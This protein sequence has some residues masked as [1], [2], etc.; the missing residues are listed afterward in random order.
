M[1]SIMNMLELVSVLGRGRGNGRVRATVSA[2]EHD[3]GS[4]PALGSYYIADID[5]IGGG[6]YSVQSGGFTG[7]SSS[8][9]HPSDDLQ[10]GTE[11]NSDHGVVD[12]SSSSLKY[13]AL[14]GASHADW[15]YSGGGASLQRVPSS[16]GHVSWVTTN[17]W[18]QDGNTC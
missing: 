18:V 15:T 13:Y 4:G 7:T 12:G 8:Q 1:G 2:H 6:S 9:A 10:T 11:T 16:Y 17:S 3:A 14:Q 5:Y